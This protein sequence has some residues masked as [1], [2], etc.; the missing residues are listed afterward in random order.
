MKPL[1]SILCL[2][3]NQEKYIAETIDS[4]LMQKTDFKFEII[5]HDDKSIDNTTRILRGYEKK[6]PEM[7]KV[8]YEDENQF[9]KGNAANFINNMY[10]DAKGKYIAW[11]EGDDYWTDP[12]KL[13]KQVDFMENNS[14]YSVSFHSAKVIYESGNGKDQIFPDKGSQKDFSINE[15]LRGNFIQTNS[16]MYRKKNSYDL[17]KNIMPL[18]WYMHI[19]HAIDGKLGFIDEVMS[20]YRKHEAGIWW[21]SQ[22]NRDKHIEKYGIEQL[23]M[24]FE[25][26]NLIE[27]NLSYRESVYNSISILIE[28]MSGTAKRTSSDILFKAIKEF[29]DNIAK[30]LVD[31][32][33]IINQL[34]N[35]Y[36]EITHKNEKLD[37]TI[38]ELKSE[39]SVIKNSRAWKIRNK[40]AKSLGKKPHY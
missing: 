22:N 12:Y 33:K 16:V 5:I 13:Q 24:Y 20:V 29:P 21:D 14:D 35:G 25:V 6:H 17:P 23:N 9:S 34:H 18:D 1:V 27:N 39:L 36:D 3:F 32:N 2:S 10:N 19:Y 4:F 15:L 8:I 31:E 38:G 11:C 7:I 30:I 26:L 37:Q 40:L 28:Q